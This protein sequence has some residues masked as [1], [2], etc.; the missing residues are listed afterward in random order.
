MKRV[1]F[2]IGLLVIVF[3][4]CKQ[5][6][7]LRSDQIHDY[8]SYQIRNIEKIEDSEKRQSLYIIHAQRGDL[9]NPVSVAPSCQI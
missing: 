1:T 4:S 7:I 8:E 6:Q 2:F 3:C 5:K 9:E